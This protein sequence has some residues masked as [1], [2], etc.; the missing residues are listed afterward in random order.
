MEHITGSWAQNQVVVTH[1]APTTL[2]I[3]AWIGMPIKAVG[4]VQ[5]PVGSGSITWLRKDTRNFSHQLVQL[6]DT[7]HL[8][9]G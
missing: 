5:F 6:N 2:L 1:G 3:A 8:S 7:S 9:R 4:R